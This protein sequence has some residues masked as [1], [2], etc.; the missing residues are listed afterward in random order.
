[1]AHVLSMTMGMAWDEL[2]IPYTDP[3]NS[4]IAME[5]APDRYRFILGR[6][7]AGEPG[8]RWTYSGGATALLGCLIARGTGQS[9]PDYAR[10]VLFEPLGIARHEWTRGADGTP[11]A[12]SG[13]RLTMRDLARV[14][15]MLL[16]KGSWQGGA[17]VPAAWIEA[18]GQPRV[19][20]EESFH[21]G[22][23]WYLYRPA[24]GRGWIG[25]IGNGGQRLYVLP[26]LDMVVVTLFGNYDHPDQRQPPLALFTE[27]I[28][29]ALR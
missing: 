27:V 7:I 5:Y 9:L 8:V 21:Y 11:S 4:E 16:Q 15:Q 2:S 17:L 23:H 13:L 6:P 29:P 18:I 12:A 10:T 25:A 22:Y 19:A 26:G 24:P 3:A 1:M 14:G 28:L 20:I